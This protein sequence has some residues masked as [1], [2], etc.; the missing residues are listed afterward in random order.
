[1]KTL[2]IIMIC[3]LSLSIVVAGGTVISLTNTDSVFT[4]SKQSLTYKNGTVSFTCGKKPMSVTIS[5]LDMNIDSDFER[6]ASMLCS[7]QITGAI[8]WTGRKYQTNEYGMRSFDQVKLNKDA[9]AKKGMIY[10]IASNQ[11]K[12]IITLKPIIPKLI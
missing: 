5:K 7:E 4:P 3:I 6:K 12:K 1:M 2:T 10:N 9:C 11:C 8:D